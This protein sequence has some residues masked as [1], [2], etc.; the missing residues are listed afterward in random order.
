MCV[1]QQ[2]AER[3]RA[4]AVRLR[5][6]ACTWDE[7]RDDPRL[8]TFTEGVL[9]LRFSSDVFPMGQ[10]SEFSPF[11]Q[12]HLAWIVGKY[13]AQWEDVLPRKQGLAHLAGLK[14]NPYKYVRSLASYASEAGVSR[15]CDGITMFFRP[16]KRAGQAGA[17]G[18]PAAA[19]KDVPVVVALLSKNGHC[20]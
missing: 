20:M 9:T 1:D 8:A 2:T 6:C 12:S 15:A 13:I 7:A 17:A 11:V 5:F 16:T 18:G 19:G 14:F 3:V 4:E 10:G